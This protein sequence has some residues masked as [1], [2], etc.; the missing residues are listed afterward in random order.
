MFVYAR[1]P[2][3]VSC[4]PDTVAA[5]P[6]LQTPDDQPAGREVPEKFSSIVK[7]KRSAPFPTVSSTTQAS[8]LPALKSAAVVSTKACAGVVKLASGDVA[9]LSAASFE[10][11]W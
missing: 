11:T 1:A 3:T 5:P 2:S 9:L 8:T 7:G 4:P 6:A 10:V